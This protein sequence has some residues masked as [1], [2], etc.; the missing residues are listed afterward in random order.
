MVYIGEIRRSFWLVHSLVTFTGLR[1]LHTLGASGAFRI[2][3]GY[4]MGMMVTKVAKLL[5]QSGIRNMIQ[6]DWW[7]QNWRSGVMVNQLANDPISTMP[8][9]RMFFLSLGW[10][11]NPLVGNPGDFI[12]IGWGFPGWVSNQSRNLITNLGVSQVDFPI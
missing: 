6:V 2:G 8:V 12:T 3:D 9:T 11:E 1:P 4:S 7:V 10:W 5:N